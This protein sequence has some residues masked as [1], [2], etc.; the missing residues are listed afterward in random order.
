MLSNQSKSVALSG[1]IRRLFRGIRRSIFRL[2][3]YDEYLDVKK[4]LERRS[5]LEEIGLITAA[6]VHDI[7]GALQV[8]ENELYH[9]RHT[10]HSNEKVMRSVNRLEQQLER[11]T[12][13]MN[14][15]KVL[16]GE[17]V[18]FE[19]YMAKT[20]VASFVNRAVRTLKLEMRTDDI[21]FKVEGKPLFI[22]AYGQMLEQ[23]LGHILKNSVEA[24]REANRRS[25]VIT[26]T[27]KLDAQLDKQVRVEIVDNGC[28]IAPENLPKITDL[29]ST[30]REKRPNSGLG[31]VM[32]SR[33]VE[34]H[35]GSLEI[36]SEYGKG[37]KVS[38]I[39]PAWKEPNDPLDSEE[40]R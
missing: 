27:I 15:V 39:F 31:L 14:I 2:S 13:S 28:G 19:R 22:K 6:L 25:G 34:V 12:D 5:V 33:V 21:F 40:L 29:F 3:Y 7:Q 20:E 30:K 16:R 8:I 35:H 24:I 26:I 38:L 11:L 37:T 23:I 18:F 10:A 17:I 9:L 32:A 1:P 36:E 4:R